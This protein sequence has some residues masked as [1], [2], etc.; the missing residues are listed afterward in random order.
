MQ[1][2][3]NVEEQQRK[4]EHERSKEEKD[5]RITIKVQTD[6][7][8]TIK[9]SENW[10]DLEDISQESE[11]W[12]QDE[13]QKKKDEQKGEQIEK[14]KYEE[15]KNDEIKEKKNEEQQEEEDIERLLK[16]PNIEACPIKNCSLDAWLSE[17]G[18]SDKS[19][20]IGNPAILNHK[21]Y[22]ALMECIRNTEDKELK[23]TA[24]VEFMENQEFNIRA[25][26]VINAMIQKI[27]EKQGESDLEKCSVGW[28]EPRDIKQ[29]RN[30]TIKDYVITN[31][32]EKK[33]N[34]FNEITSLSQEEY[35]QI[36]L[37]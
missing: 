35:Q 22:L 8:E 30:E 34:I 29:E 20:N 18:L 11:E 32:L 13:T 15:A 6:A 3:R 26:G 31:K 16:D 33:Q 19:N 36:L 5:E 24:K 9:K 1:K 2:R 7:K 14:E 37:N 17:V 27:K 21:K 25:K 28:K 10:M 12:E 4:N 23:R